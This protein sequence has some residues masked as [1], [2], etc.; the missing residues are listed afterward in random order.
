MEK[1]IVFYGVF[2]LV[3]GLSIS[4]AQIIVAEKNISSGSKTEAAKLRQNDLIGSEWLSNG[5]NYFHRQKYTYALD[6]Y[7]KAHDYFKDSEDEYLKHRLLCNLAVIKGYLGYTEKS[8]SLLKQC[9]S[10]YQSPSVHSNYDYHKLYVRTLY[11]LSSIYQQTGNYKTARKVL[12]SA[13]SET[14]DSGFWYERALIYKSLGIQYFYEKEHV[15]SLRLLNENLPVFLKEDVPDAVAL[16]YFYIAKNH[17]ELN[18]SKIALNYFEKVDSV[19]KTRNYMTPRLRETYEILLMYYRQLNDK[20]QQLYYA[21]R[22]MEANKLIEN[23]FA[24]LN[25][26]LYKKKE[27]DTEYLL[28]EKNKLTQ[29]NKTQASFFSAFIFF[30]GLIFV[31]TAYWA[32]RGYRRN[33]Q[34]QKTSNET[35]AAPPIPKDSKERLVLLKLDAD[36]ANILLEKLR[37]FEAEKG[38]IQRG[39]SIEI[40]AKKLKTNSHYLSE[41]INSYMGKNFHSYLNELRINYLI[42][43]LKMNPQKR[44]MKLEVIARET[45]FSNRQSFARAFQSVVRVSPSCFIGKL[46]EKKIDALTVN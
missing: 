43:E 5:E 44:K 33:K 37:M 17:F 2:Y 7:L 11:Q 14:K 13:L 32:F 45:G 23:D 39:L 21:H 16:S 38:F 20:D 8:I 12:K 27:L 24:Y 1:R 26:A 9:S 46:E 25:S 35:W 34:L 19:F 18:E 42:D 31:V 28:S 3:A 29:I 41:V 36:K 10:Y 15:K 30:G 40:L 6:N 4:M 22:L